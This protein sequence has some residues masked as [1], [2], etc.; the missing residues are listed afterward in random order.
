MAALTLTCLHHTAADRVT[1]SRLFRLIS[2]ARLGTDLESLTYFTPSYYVRIGHCCQLLGLQL[3]LK[4]AASL[5]MC[6]SKHIN[7]QTDGALRL[8]LPW[9]SISFIGQVC[10][11]LLGQRAQ[12]IIFVQNTCLISTKHVKV[13]CCRPTCIIV[14]SCGLPLSQNIQ[15]RCVH[16]STA[17]IACLSSS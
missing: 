10:L 7:R 5:A 6:Q 14:M 15:H 17:G 1:F 11:S 12:D 4:L 9:I 13:T 8:I 3:W 16:N 2:L